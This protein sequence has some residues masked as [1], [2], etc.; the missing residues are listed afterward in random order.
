MTTQ[1][2]ALSTQVWTTGT[3]TSVS[4]GPRASCALKESACT[5]AE[6]SAQDARGPEE[7]EFVST[8]CALVRR[9][10]SPVNVLRLLELV[11]DRDGEVLAAD[12][13][14]ALGVLDEVIETQSELARALARLDRGGRGDG[15]PV[16]VGCLLHLVEGER[17]GL[18]GRRLDALLGHVLEVGAAV[19]A[20]QAAGTDHEQAAFDARLADRVEYLLDV[21]LV[22]LHRDD[23]GVMSFK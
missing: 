8:E 9:R 5:C 16:E 22:P 12:A 1:G 21:G 13:A 15:G 11:E 17:S 4:S 3:T 18:G 2:I 19:L 20:D 23:D 6:M 10:E 7:H 14:L